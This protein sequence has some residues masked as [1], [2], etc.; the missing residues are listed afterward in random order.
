MTIE[1]TPTLIFDFD[2][3]ICNS[4]DAAILSLNQFSEKYGYKK[5]TPDMVPQLRLKSSHDVLKELGVSLIQLPF[6][7]PAVKKAFFQLVPQLKPFDGILETFEF[8]KQRKIRCGI[9]TS[10]SKETVTHFNEM[11]HLSY[12]DFIYSGVSFFGKDKTLNRA[13]KNH[14]LSKSEVIYVGDETRD[15]EAAR[16]VG[17]K[18]IS[19]SWGFHSSELLKQYSPDYLIHHPH[20][21][22]EIVGEI[23]GS[24]F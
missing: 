14:Q 21:L 19:V 13:I 15:I 5:I 16:Q 17:I 2:G 23:R 12:F 20:E 10:N 24:S 9:L 3:T 22:R 18:M 6:L 8:L 7:A 1:S 4:L 11:N